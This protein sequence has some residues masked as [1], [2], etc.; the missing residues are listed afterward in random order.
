MFL[1]CAAGDDAGAAA[2]AAAGAGLL[3]KPGSQDLYAAKPDK[4]NGNPRQLSSLQKQDVD[5]RIL[6]A[7]QA[8][9]IPANPQGP[10]K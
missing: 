4:P 2:T 9:R 6:T 5:T 7:P 1:H 8:K 3:S 10:S